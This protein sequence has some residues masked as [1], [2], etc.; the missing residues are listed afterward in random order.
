MR[1]NASLSDFGLTSLFTLF[2]YNQVIN[3]IFIKTFLIFY[4]II[5]VYYTTFPHLF[6]LFKKSS[7][8]FGD[9]LI[10]SVLYMYNSIN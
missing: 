10:D 4:L 6:L 7:N 3:I 8:L 5:Y 2:F 1:N 9:W